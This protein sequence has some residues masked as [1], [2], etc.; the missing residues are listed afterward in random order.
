MVQG[1]SLGPPMFPIGKIAAPQNTRRFMVHKM[2]LHKCNANAIN[3]A[4][5]E[6]LT[7]NNEH[8]GCY[9]TL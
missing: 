1:G 5:V 3:K 2:V 8:S 6:T 7:Q 9:V 4:S